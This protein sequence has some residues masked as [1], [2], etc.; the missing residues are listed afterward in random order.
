MFV[1]FLSCQLCEERNRTGLKI[2]VCVILAALS[3]M[4]VPGIYNIIKEIRFSIP[5]SSELVS[6]GIWDGAERERRMASEM[7]GAVFMV[8]AFL[9]G[10][11]WLASMAELAGYVVFAA[12]LVIGFIL[13]RPAKEMLGR[14]AFN[15]TRFAA[16]YGLSEDKKFLKY[17]SEEMKP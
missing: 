1:R 9:G 3:C 8:L 10:Q 17:Y 6:R 4:S 5:F 15:I 12:S 2:L 16:K 13:F 14:S 7:F 11:I